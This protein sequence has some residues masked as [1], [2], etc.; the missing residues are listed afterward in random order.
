[1]RI[2]RSKTIFRRLMLSNLIIVIVGI[3]A[4]GMAIS[5]LVKGYL[6]EAKQLELLREA[7]KVNLSIQAF[8]GASEGSKEIEELKA[9][10]VFFDQTFEA[11]IWV[12]DDTGRILATSAQDEVSVGK[13]VSPTIVEQVMRGEHAVNALRFEGLNEPMLSIAIPWGIEE[14]LF[15]GIVMHTPTMETSGAV[16]NVRE[17][18]LWMTL[19]GLL[20]SVIMVSYVSWSIARPMQNI[21]RVATEIGMGRY[22][23]RAEGRVADEIDDLAHG[24]NA[25]GGKLQRI[26][27]ERKKADR[28]RDDFLANI[29]HELRTPLNS[30]QG[31]LEALQDGLIP[32]E[33]R[34]KYYDVM[35]QETLQ[36]N[37][38]VDDLIDLIKLENHEI[39]LERHPLD[40]EPL[41]QK[42]AIKFE[43][44]VRERGLEPR[45]RMADDLPKVNADVDRLEQILANLITNAI[46]FTEEGY[47]ELTASYDSGELLLT[48]ADTGVG[49]SEHDLNRIWERFFKT[50]RGRSRKNKGAG[51]GLA[52]V[53]ELVELHGGAIS[54]R[55]GLNEGT[56]FE[57]RLDARETGG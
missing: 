27:E 21:A 6:Y 10:L 38:L 46:K 31:F 49:I 45:I 26:E 1:M 56:T 4:V 25:L 7:K 35:Y 15:G 3:G 51:L 43:Q 29:S 39:K 57:L 34:R 32:E 42:L 20:G 22:D 2:A 44:E 19:F 17:A 23:S 55:S 40:I 24:V 9:L 48:V 14:Q 30:M 8:A 54:A 12:F 50:D 36:M 37:R 11:R 28:I 53:K 41:Y 16:G 13:S 52:I 5:Y 18:V 33:G 47:I